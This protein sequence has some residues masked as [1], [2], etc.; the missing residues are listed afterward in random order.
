MPKKAL[1]TATVQSHIAQFHEPAI[2]LLQEHGYEVHVAARDNLSQKS[3]LTLT[4]PDR[5]FDVPFD[6]SP[7]SL[8]N[9]RAFQRLRA[10]VRDGDYDLIHC[11]TPVAGIVTRLV[12]RRARAAGARLVYTAHGFH[13]YDGAPPLNWLVYYP[14][15]RI[16]SRL[17]DV[18]VTINKQDHARATRF[19]PGRVTY[20]PGVGVDLRRFGE[21]PAPG[22]ALRREFGLSESD[23]V[24]LSIGELNENKNHATVL[25]AAAQCAVP[26]LHYLICGNGPKR[27]ELADLVGELGLDGRVQF[28]GYRRDIPQVLG[29]ADVFCLPSF[30]EG[31]PLALMEAMAAGKPVVCSGIRGSVDLVDQGQGG[32]VVER[33]DDVAGFAEALETLASEE[34]VR[35][36]MAVHNRER[37]RGFSTD[38]VTAGLME[39]YGLDDASVGDVA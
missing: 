4:A 35:R 29:V 38:A 32:V 12:G 8:S 18:L 36:G 39:V 31:L 33:A 30:R 20:V 14:L 19:A 24:V 9:V 37:V 2:R 15:E 11:N 26:K 1:F 25:K 10:I 7:L 21:S 23:F 17:T 13:F 5:V 34:V 6:R 22:A 27:Q 28:L 16:F 3:G